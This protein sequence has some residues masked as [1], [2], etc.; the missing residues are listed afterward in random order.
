MENIGAWIW[1]GLQ[2]LGFWQPIMILPPW[3][4]PAV[5]IGALLALAALCGI[6]V[7]SIATLLAALLTAHLLLERVFGVSVDLVP[8]R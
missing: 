7:L 6:A 5:A 8:V 2:P 4:A 1:R 3:A